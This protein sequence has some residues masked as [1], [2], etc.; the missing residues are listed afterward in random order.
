MHKPITDLIV[1]ISW[2]KLTRTSQLPQSCHKFGH[3]F[4]RSMITIEEFQT[5]RL[6]WWCRIFMF[7]NQ[8]SQFF[9]TFVFRKFTIFQQVLYQLVRL[10]T[11]WSQQ[12]IP[13]CLASSVTPHASK[14]ISRRS[15]YESHGSSS[16]Y[17][18]IPTACKPSAILFWLP[19]TPTHK[20]T[21]ITPQQRRVNSPK[22]HNQVHDS[23]PKCDIPRVHISG[24]L[25]VCARVIWP[26]RHGSTT[27][28]FGNSNW[29]VYIII[30]IQN[31]EKLGSVLTDP[32][33]YSPHV[34]P[35]NFAIWGTT[36]C[37][38]L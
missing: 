24:S 22:P 16:V 2:R 5:L 27:R 38:T 12:K 26:A 14:Y 15:T 35:M 3:S 4:I 31:S 6:P 11:N 17:G 32:H 7:T 18:P 29:T 1:K 19:L 33:Y 23:S 9:V 13:R 37:N 30:G 36:I 21:E 10:F 28:H 8:I 34:G 25:N 20:T